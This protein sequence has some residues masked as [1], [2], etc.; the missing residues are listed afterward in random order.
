MNELS[1]LAQ[2]EAHCLKLLSLREHSQQEL[3]QKL[4]VKGFEVDL[5][6]EIIDKLAS[7]NWQS[8]ARYAENYAR[9]RFNNGFGKLKIAYELKLHGIKINEHQ[10]PFNESDEFSMLCQLYQKKYSTDQR[11]DQSE[12]AKRSRFFLQRGFSAGLINKLFKHLNLRFK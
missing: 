1:P 2:I 6:R 9:S 11:L 5:I 8:D 12:W 4:T 7:Q 3:L 10:L